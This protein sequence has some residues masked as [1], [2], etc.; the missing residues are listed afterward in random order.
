MPS[1]ESNGRRICALVACVLVA[2]VCAAAENPPAAPPS[3]ARATQEKAAGAMQIPRVSGVVRLPIGGW[4]AAG[5][6]QPGSCTNANC[7]SAACRA[8]TVRAMPV[9]PPPAAAKLSGPAPV[10][11]VPVNATNWQQ[12]CRFSIVGLELGVAYRIVAT[13]PYEAWMPPQPAGSEFGF[14][15]F[16]PSQAGSFSLTP[17]KTGFACP[18]IQLI[19]MP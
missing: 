10:H 4:P 7:V 11:P 15:G 8:A 14:K 2:A 6:D 3:A 1:P 9:N 16:C 19:R 18:D 17:A 13:L 5:G 12:G